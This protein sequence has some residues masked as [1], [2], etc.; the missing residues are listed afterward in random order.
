M[1]SVHCPEYRIIFPPPTPPILLL[2]QDADSLE[3]QYTEMITLLDEKYNET[4][5]IKQRADRLRDR[6]AELYQ[7][8][9]EKVQLLEGEQ[10]KSFLQDM[11]G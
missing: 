2:L 9:Y 10:G 4:V 1:R 3:T 11:S 6:A 8:T 7:S 5:I